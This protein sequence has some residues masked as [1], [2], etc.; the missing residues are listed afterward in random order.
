M[1]IDL[2]I[3]KL[4]KIYLYF[5]SFCVDSFKCSMFTNMS[6]ANKDSFT[7]A[8]LIHRP[9]SFTCSIAMT[10]TS[11]TVLN[12]NVE[13][14]YSS[15][16]LISLEQSISSFTF[17]VVLKYSHNFSHTPLLR[18]CSLFPSPWMQAVVSALLLMEMLVERTVTF[19][20]SG[21]K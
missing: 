15:L 13:S 2:V 14:I 18:E 5:S 7:S 3:I 11:R 20:R 1:Y 6:P 8:F 4:C 17:V 10:R 9:C 21:H 12:K 19:R 16:F